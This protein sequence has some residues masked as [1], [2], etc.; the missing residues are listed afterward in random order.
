MGRSLGGRITV[1]GCKAIHD[2]LDDASWPPCESKWKRQLRQRERFASPKSFMARP[3]YACAASIIAH[4]FAPE[5]VPTAL[6]SASIAS[7]ARG[8]Q[9]NNPVHSYSRVHAILVIAPQFRYP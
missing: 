3:C 6:K 9:H 5:N 7:T 1:G 4:N 2:G 8:L